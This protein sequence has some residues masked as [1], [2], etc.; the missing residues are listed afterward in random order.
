VCKTLLDFNTIQIV[1]FL[2][3]RALDQRGWDFLPSLEQQSRVLREQVKG[4]TNLA[5]DCLKKPGT[6]CREGEGR[7]K[8]MVRVVELSP[9]RPRLHLGPAKVEEYEV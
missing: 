3:G 9:D 2:P 4:V 8:I 6:M 5:I 1:Y 7:K